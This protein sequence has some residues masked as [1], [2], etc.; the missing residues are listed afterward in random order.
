MKVEHYNVMYFLFCIKREI[1]VQGT[2]DQY[3]IQGMYNQLC[4]VLVKGQWFNK[5]VLNN[6][7]NFNVPVY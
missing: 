4:L 5:C 3:I 2:Y 6:Y 1:V 7:R